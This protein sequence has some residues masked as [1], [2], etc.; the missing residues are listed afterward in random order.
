MQWVQQNIKFF[1]GDP[2][3]VTLFGQSAGAG[4]TTAHLISPK[5]QGLFNQ[6]IIES[7]PF[8]LPLKPMVLKK[9]INL[10]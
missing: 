5:S 2:N 4:S 10:L 1:G 6:A 8:T 3:Q 9:L 7:N